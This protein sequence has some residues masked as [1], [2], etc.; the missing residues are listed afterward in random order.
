MRNF[1]IR[2]QVEDELTDFASKRVKLASLQANDSVRFLRGAPSHG[3]LFN[4]GQT[5][6]LI[7]LYY[8]SKFENSE[9]DALGQ[10]KIFM[11]VGK[12]RTDVAAKQI[13][14]DT[15]NFRFVPDD[16]ADP[17]PAFFLQKDFKEWA[18][19]SYFGELVNK[20]VEAL[21]KYGTV[22]LKKVGKRQVHFMP[23]QN[24]RNEQTADSLKTASYVIEEHPN[25]YKWE[26][27]AM[28]SWNLD[29]LPL[30]FNEAI[31]VY[32]RYGHVP[33][34]WLRKV[35]GQTFEDADWDRS[36]DA[37]VVV[38]ILKKESRNT[39]EDMV[40]IFMAEEITE[41]PYEEVHWQQQHG[42]WLGIG[43]MEDLLENQIAK[44]III[45]LQRRSLHWSSKRIGKTAV[46][47]LAAKNLV[48][49]VKDGELLDLGPN[50]DIQL[51]DLSSRNQAEFQQVL[52]EWEKNSDQKAFTYEVATGAAL[53]SG[54][55][56]RL[57]VVLSQ[58]TNSYFDLKREKLGLFLKRA[59][60]QFMI[61][62]FLKDM[63]DKE[64]IVSFFSDEPGY[65][66]LKAAGIAW[67][68]SEAVR[69]TLLSGNPALPTEIDSIAQ[70]FESARSLPFSLPAN[71]YQ[72]VKF[73]FDFTVTGEEIDIEAKLET[74][75]TLYQ[76]LQAVGDPRAE[77][78]LER[79]SA[80]AGENMAAFGLPQPANKPVAPAAPA[81]A[82][83]AAPV[84][85]APV[86]AGPGA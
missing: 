44:N 22:V 4:Q 68:K 38:A 42:R 80:I 51:L 79:I 29:G 62:Q 54:T 2:R 75:K 78:V 10:R 23:L 65:E 64:R 17:W 57:G 74:L 36:V 16:Y 55:P 85:P 15:K 35:N 41:R 43:V 34:A 46:A 32:E 58:A 63:G 25:M 56:F 69:I 72:D 12:F 20:C 76:S 21:P 67:V 53:P 3:Y 82:A 8:N 61:P 33:V 9:I 71:Y 13:D 59:I 18:K 19:E 7:D 27:E 14:L 31:T 24:L 47:D 52:N 37:L 86:N 6:S 49:D 60:N 39:L 11:N 84:A 77:R 83:P 70:P 81:N 1:S 50:G 40:H 26:M 5:I 28:T 73:K 48:K 30:K 45:N 66:A